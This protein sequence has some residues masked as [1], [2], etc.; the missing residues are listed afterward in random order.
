VPMLLVSGFVF[1][2]HASSLGSYGA[3]LPPSDAV[4][5]RMR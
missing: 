4:M 1:T 2:H 5:Q 3:F